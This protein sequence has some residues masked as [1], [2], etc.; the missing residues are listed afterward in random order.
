[1]IF[2]TKYI[3]LSQGN[4]KSG[5]FQ[6]VPIRYKDRL[7][8]MKWRNE[9]MYHLRQSEVITEENQDDYYKD[10]ISKLFTKKKPNQLLFS[11]LKNDKCIGY[12]GLVHIDWE[13]KSAEISFI[14]NTSLEEDYFEILW[15]EFLIL[16]EKVAFIYLNFNTIFT[17]AFDLRPNLYPILL[18]NNYPLK[19]RIKHQLHIDNKW[20][21]VVIHEKKNQLISI[22]KSTKE[23]GTLLFNW[24]NEKAVRTQSFNSTEIKLDK[25]FEWYNSKLKDPN[26]IFYILELKRQPFGLIRIEIGINHSTIGISIDEKYRGQGLSSKALDIGC[27]EYFRKEKKPI[28]AFIKKTNIF[29]IKTFKSIGFEFLNKTLINGIPSFT[30]Q[31]KNHE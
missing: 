13:N 26:F 11:F 28:F 25:H 1:M 3:A 24:A 23:N 30:Y 9:Q 31:L 10:I 19:E 4:F 22:R 20:F 27:R 17:Y 29:S 16:I 14:M 5:E 2:P 15:S 6:I 18:K 12:G 8:I 21:D 7:D